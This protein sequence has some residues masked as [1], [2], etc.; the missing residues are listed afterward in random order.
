MDKWY[1][2]TWRQR[3]H[4]GTVLHAGVTQGVKALPALLDLAQDS[5]SPALVRA[6]AIT[7]IEP[8]MRP[9]FLTAA[10]L[11]LQDADP[12]V[13]I[14]AL[15]LIE[16]VDPVNRVL[17]AAPLLADPIRGVRIEAA[18][19]LA[20]VPDDQ[21]PA[22]GLATAKVRLRSIRITCAQCRLAIRKR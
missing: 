13:R 5:S 4:Y 15:G 21:F 11:L 14:A 7:L 8:M 6:T 16:A 18:R 12:S 1:G 22:N 17:A 20:D 2:K 10:R 3:P 9:E 19:I